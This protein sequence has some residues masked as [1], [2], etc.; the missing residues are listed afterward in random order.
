MVV[1]S[2]LFGDIL[3]DLSGVVTG[4]IGLATAR[5]SIRRKSSPACLSR[6]WQRPDIAGKGIANPLAAILTAV[7]LLDHLGEPAASIAVRN[8]VA[9][10]LKEGKVMPPISAERPRR[11]KWGMR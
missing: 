1:A 11:R 6:S 5:I 3:T 9:K 8:A 7:L 2:N 4:S 10:V